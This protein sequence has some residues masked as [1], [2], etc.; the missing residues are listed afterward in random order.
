MQARADRTYQTRDFYFAATLCA[1]GMEL[2]DLDRADPRHAGF[3]FRDD[4]RRREWTRQY[5]AGELRLDPVLLFN[6]SRGLKRAVYETGQPLPI[7]VM[8]R[9]AMAAS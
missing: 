8:P 7:R 9:E 2:I 5:F 6:S 1:L 3:V 4:R